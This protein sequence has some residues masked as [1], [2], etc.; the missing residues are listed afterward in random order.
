V[1]DR[2]KIFQPRLVYT[3][4]QY[5]LTKFRADIL[6]G[7]NGPSSAGWWDT[8]FFSVAFLVLLGV[9]IWSSENI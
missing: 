8:F 2:D 6:A 1:P 4:S 5:N 9:H 7:V 3:L